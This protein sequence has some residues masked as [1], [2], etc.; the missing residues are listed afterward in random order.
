MPV[1]RTVHYPGGGEALSQ[2][3]THVEPPSHDALARHPR[4]SRLW[5]VGVFH[6]ALLALRRLAPLSPLAVR[7]RRFRRD[8]LRRD[9]HVA[10]SVLPRLIARP[11]GPSLD[12]KAG[13]VSICRHAPLPNTKRPPAEAGGLSYLCYRCGPALERHLLKRRNK[14]DARN[15]EFVQMLVVRDK[16]VHSKMRGTGQLDCIGTA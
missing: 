5:L 12:L 16:Q 13:F 4:L 11:S 10:H 14:A 3:S 9:S 2:Q 1:L 7:S 15:I 8:G 6:P